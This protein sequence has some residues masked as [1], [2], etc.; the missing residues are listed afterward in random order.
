MSNV[1]PGGDVSAHYPCDSKR[2]ADATYLRHGPEGSRALQQAGYV[3][4]VVGLFGAFWGVA[5]TRGVLLEVDVRSVIQGLGWPLITLG[6][7]GVVGSVAVL[8]RRLGQVRGPVVPSLPWIDLVVSTSLDRGHVLKE[9][10]TVALLLMVS[11]FAI[12]ALVIGVSGVFV[13]AWSPVWIVGW[14][15]FGLALGWVAARAALAGQ[16]SRG[17]GVATTFGRNGSANRPALRSAAALRAIGWVRLREHSARSAVVHGSV[18]TGDLRVAQLTLRPPRA[19]ARFLRLRASGPL[20]T[21]VRR[22]LLAYRRGPHRFVTA[23]FLMTAG[24]GGLCWALTSPNAP[25]TGIVVAIAVM[26][27]GCGLLCEGVRLQSDTAGAPSLLGLGPRRHL[28]A[29]LVAPGLTCL[30][31][32]LGSFIVVA[33][34]LLGSPAV[35]PVKPVFIG[36]WVLCILALCVT[37]QAWSAFRES[38]PFGLVTSPAGPVITALWHAYPMAMVTIG[39]GFISAESA[40]ETIWWCVPL[41]VSAAAVM[42]RWAMTG[43]D[44]KTDAHRL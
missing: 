24:C 42:V 10:W 17:E 40:G 35:G 28:L 15:T 18:V 1:A 7:I 25:I 37:G 14:V 21:V 29:H 20:R 11:V 2:L 39:S 33:L 22:D 26:Y 8:A 38:V 13:A 4:Y 32:G 19:S 5:I 43:L 12:G 41:A 31:V 6:A 30:I 9:L 3:L 36:A 34:L 16:G 27:A 44:T 23:V